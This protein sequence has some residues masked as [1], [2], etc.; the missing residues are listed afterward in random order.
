M[1]EGIT[2]PLRLCPLHRPI[3][4][5]FDELSTIGANPEMFSGHNRVYHTSSDIDTM[6]TL[7]G[8]PDREREVSRRVSEDALKGSH[9]H[10]I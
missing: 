6:P 8:S 9:E 2:G 4:D 3:L 10:D 5:G 7:S 1:P